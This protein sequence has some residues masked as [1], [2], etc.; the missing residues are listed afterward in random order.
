MVVSHFFNVV[1]GVR[2]G[3]VLSPLFF[4]IFIDQLGVKSM[5]YIISTVCCAVYFFMLMT[6]Y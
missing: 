1:A 2:Q 6:F 4:T 3:I 5:Y